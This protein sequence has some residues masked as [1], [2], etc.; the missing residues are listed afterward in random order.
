MAP[1][2]PAITYR[3]GQPS[4]VNHIDKNHR[5]PRA[6][7]RARSRSRLRL[8]SSRL[9]HASG[10]GERIS[11]YRNGSRACAASK[12][13][14]LLAPLMRSFLTVGLTSAVSAT[15]NRSAVK[16]S[17][18]SSARRPRSPGRSG[19]SA[20][21]TMQTWAIRAASC[22]NDEISSCALARELTL[23]SSAKY[24]AMRDATAISKSE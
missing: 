10:D 14:P 4:G 6:F 1:D 16:S 5:R 23:G 20:R 18:Q 9:P 11:G 21:A 12:S 8:R 7:C 19:R 13:Q 22:R 3:D 15:S 24:F 17:Y 2:V